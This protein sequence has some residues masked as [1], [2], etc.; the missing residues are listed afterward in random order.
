MKFKT[1]VYVVKKEGK[2]FPIGTPKIIKEL[3]VGDEIYFEIDPW[4]SSRRADNVIL[5]HVTKGEEYA[6]VKGKLF[7]AIQD[8]GLALK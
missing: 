2:T 3:A 6:M 8:I 1:D 5:H 4:Q 7:S